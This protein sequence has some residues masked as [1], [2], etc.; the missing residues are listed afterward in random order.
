MMRLPGRVL[1][2]ALARGESSA[3]DV[4]EECLDAPRKSPT[5]FLR[6]CSPPS[7]PQGEREMMRQN[8]T[9][10]ERAG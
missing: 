5:V 7:D 4:L 2:R 3:T 1:S 6:R 10:K 8:A 9:G